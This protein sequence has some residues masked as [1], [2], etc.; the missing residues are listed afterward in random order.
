MLDREK[1]R[2]MV[3]AMS[4]NSGPK[5]LLALTPVGFVGAIG[6]LYGEQLLE[7]FSGSGSYA[8]PH[9]EAVH[10]P[11]R[12]D[13]PTTTMAADVQ[14]IHTAINTDQLRLI[15]MADAQPGTFDRACFDAHMQI[16]NDRQLEIDRVMRDYPKM[17]PAEQQ[18]ARAYIQN[19]IA[20]I[21]GQ[22]NAAQRLFPQPPFGVP[23]D[24]CT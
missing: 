1:K 8:P 24:Y 21:E 7:F 5:I 4:L 22:M 11:I 16:I 3:G 13:I 12:L 15:S 10:L 17:S 6:Y 2:S 14:A 18:N 23:R 19:L 9:P 20:Q